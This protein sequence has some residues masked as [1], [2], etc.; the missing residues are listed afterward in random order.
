MIK[1][2][3]LRIGNKILLNGSID[4]VTGI[5]N[6]LAEMEG[7]DYL[8]QNSEYLDYSLDKIEPIPL[9]PEIL[10]KVG[11]EKSETGIKDCYVYNLILA[12][13]PLV[14]ILNLELQYCDKDLICEVKLLPFNTS[15]YKYLHELQ[16]IW[17]I[18]SGEELPINEKKFIKKNNNL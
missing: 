17:F 18:L 11:F 16:N 15:K 10:E 4:T 2:N 3:D 14:S 5:F 9:T 7:I 6:Q 13:S 8:I 12:E 1:A